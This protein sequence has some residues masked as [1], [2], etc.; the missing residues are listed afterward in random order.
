MVQ[1]EGRVPIESTWIIEGDFM[2]LDLL[3][4]YHFEE[5]DLQELHSFQPAENDAGI[6]EGHKF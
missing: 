5:S 4:W 3:K 1:W 6:F 2:N